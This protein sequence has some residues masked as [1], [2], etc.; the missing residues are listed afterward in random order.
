MYPVAIVNPRSGHVLDF[1][2]GKSTIPWLFLNQCI[3]TLTFHD[4][5]VLKSL[6]RG[7]ME[8][9]LKFCVEV[10]KFQ[11]GR[12]G[13]RRSHCSLCQWDKFHEVLHRDEEIH[14]ATVVI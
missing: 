8:Q 6:Q 10:A 14:Q 3:R 1:E 12:K 9:S 5:V 2:I 4:C 11:H 13:L 7:R